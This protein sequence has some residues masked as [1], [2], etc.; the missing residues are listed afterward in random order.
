M[1][2]YCKHVGVVLHW[3]EALSA[4][5]LSGLVQYNEGEETTTMRR[6][7]LPVVFLSTIAITAYAAEGEFKV[8]SL[9][10]R[11]EIHEIVGITVGNGIEDSMGE[12]R[13]CSWAGSMPDDL[14][15]VVSFQ[16]AAFQASCEKRYKGEKDLGRRVEDLSDFG[17]KAWWSFQRKDPA[18]SIVAMNVCGPKGI[19]RM[20]VWGTAEEEAMKKMAEELARKAFSRL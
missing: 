17:N 19:L 15:L 10:T 3:E 5:V 6:I 2:E 13:Q 20:S 18:L 14:S 16:K 4:K 1:Q 8:C 11:N 9:L 7:L 12:V